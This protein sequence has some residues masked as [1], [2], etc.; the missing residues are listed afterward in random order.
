MAKECVDERVGSNAAEQVPCN[1]Q[2][3]F[4]FLFQPFWQS[5]KSATPTKNKL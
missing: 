1:P 5:Y 4:L 3:L 2:T